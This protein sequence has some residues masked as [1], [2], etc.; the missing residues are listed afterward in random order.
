[1]ALR[2]PIRWI[3]G[4]GKMTKKIL[5]FFP[6]HKRYVEAFGGGASLL[7]AKRPVR[8]EV[9]NDLNTNLVQLFR[10]LQRSGQLVFTAVALTPFSRREQRHARE[11]LDRSGADVLVAYR[12]SFGGKISGYG[13]DRSGSTVRGYWSNVNNL[14]RLS[15]RLENVT[16][17]SQDGLDVIRQYDSPETLHYLDPPYVP[18]SWTN[19]DVYS[20]HLMTREQHQ[21]LVELLLT[22]KGM[23][24]LSGYPNDVYA[25]LTEA[26]TT[27]EFSVSCSVAARTQSHGLKGSGNVKKQQP[28]TECLWLNPQATRNMI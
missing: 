25:P 3:G 2:S 8:F 21:E 12:Q 13:I 18:D 22:V 24:V 4:K 6:R 16:I 26:W 15:R 17:L 19:E 7:L 1:M 11:H 20:G 27:H 23:V 5:P 9:Y 28:R 10:D 14:R